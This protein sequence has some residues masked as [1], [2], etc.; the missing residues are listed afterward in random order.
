MLIA[1]SASAR[2]AGLK[3]PDANANTHAGIGVGV[4]LCSMKEP[5]GPT[6]LEHV[7]GHI[8]GL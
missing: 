8:F 3:M 1:R 7:F 5:R 6:L 4:G 2:A